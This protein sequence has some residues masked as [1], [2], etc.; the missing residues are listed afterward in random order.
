[1]LQNNLNI[2]LRYSLLVCI[3]GGQKKP[4][5]SK[6]KKMLQGKKGKID[7]KE[8]KKKIEYGVVISP[9]ID[10]ELREFISKQ[11]YV[12]PYIVSKKAEVKVGEARRYLKKLANEGVIKLVIKNR[13]TEV[14]QPLAS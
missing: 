5:I 1:M 7:K 9:D 14:Y 3:M 11:R 13:E 4:T 12:T 2:I 6:L 10:K 8:E